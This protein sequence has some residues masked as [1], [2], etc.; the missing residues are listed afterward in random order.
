MI[1]PA[2]RKEEKERR[3][4]RSLLSEWHGA[5]YAHTE[6]SAYAPGVVSLDDA[7]DK[8]AGR[9]FTDTTRRQMKLQLHWEEIAG[10]Q[11]AALTKVEALQGEVLYL[12]VRHS[13]FLRELSGTED[14][15]IQAVNRAL[16]GKYCRSVRF[17]AGSMKR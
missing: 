11:L 16:G 3:K 8:I 4:I 15:L 13:A 10:R 5:F 6:S 7:L 2:L 14:L 1:S 17:T 12:A 9:I